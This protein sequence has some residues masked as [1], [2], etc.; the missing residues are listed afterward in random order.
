[1]NFKGTKGDDTLTG[2]SANDTFDVSQGGVDNLSGKGG[3]DLFIFGNTLRANDTINGGTGS[4]AVEIGG[5]YGAGFAWGPNTF[6]SVET[7]HL[8]KGHGY[9]F[10]SNEAN[11]A[12]GTTLTIDAS[13]LRSSDH[14][15]FDGSAETDGSFTFI[16]GLGTYNLLG[17]NHHADDVQNDYFKFS[18]NF[19]S[20]DAINGQQGTDHLLL[21][22]DY[23]GSAALNLGVDQMNS[24]EV[25]KMGDAAGETSGSYHITAVDG[26]FGDGSYAFLPVSFFMGSLD[27]GSNVFIDDSAESTI[28]DRFFP[29]LGTYD[30]RAG[31]AIKNFFGWGGNW[32]PADSVRGGAG[33]DTLGFNAAFLTP[34]LDAD[35]TG[36]NAVTLGYL[37]T[38]GIE[39]FGFTG[40]FSYD[41]TTD[42]STVHQLKVLT[43]NE[44]GYSVLAGG[45]DQVMMAAMGA[46]DHL[47]FDGSAETTGQFLFLSGNGSDNLTG[48]SL[49]DT[50]DYQNI[51]L[52]GDTRDTI[53]AFDFS[54]DIVQ[55]ANVTSIDAA[56]T[57]GSA[58]DATIDTDLTALFGNGQTHELG[59][60]HVVLFT[61]DDG[62]LSGDT[63]LIV[64]GDGTAGYT[65]GHDLVIQLEGALNSGGI[66]TANFTA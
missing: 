1:M 10:T 64:D 24:I 14:L 27:A 35:Y 55:F 42:E 36:S 60:N 2:T 20:D 53:H 49:A 56:V 19:G 4:D 48:G 40:G 5:M 45:T 38:V 29:G 44:Q 26:A 17:G 61:A 6:S 30:L 12:A 9:N 63:F 8:D 39:Q 25:I 51:T 33:F 58:S 16:C 52:S 11:V 65:A 41:V 46:G 37:Q 50:F 43:V 21:N 23:T 31:D 66:S 34:A 3:A 59:A 47:M 54:N 18:G 28:E 62:D 13:N 57:S 22:G 32:N 15:T 7:I